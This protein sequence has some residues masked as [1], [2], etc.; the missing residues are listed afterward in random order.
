MLAQIYAP[1]GMAGVQVPRSALTTAVRP[2]HSE[3]GAVRPAQHDTPLAAC[4]PTAQLPAGCAE[5]E[6]KQRRHGAGADDDSSLAGGADE[7]AHAPEPLHAAAV[8]ARYPEAAPRGAAPALSDAEVASLCFPHGLA[9]EKLRR[10]P[11]L[12][13][14]AEVVYSRQAA[15]GDDSQAV[16]ML[17]VRVGGARASAGGGGGGGG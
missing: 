12:S 1:A 13:G 10:T 14:L 16:F 5:L 4:S 2:C 11:S 8:I 17:K 6:R 3:A 7:H 9:P 15:G